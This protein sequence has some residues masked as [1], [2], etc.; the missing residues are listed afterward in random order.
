MGR[1]D[2]HRARALFR[3]SIFVRDDGDQTP[4][5]RQAHELAD[6]MLIA[7]VLGMDGNRRIAQHGFGAGGRHDNL[8]RAVFQRIGEVPIE[9]VNL[10]LLDLE[11]GDGG[12]ELRVPIDQTLVAIDQALLVEG[13]KDL[14]H[15]LGQA[16]I[17]GK[18]LAAPVAGDPKTTKLVL[19]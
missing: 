13:D 10:T 7:F 16:L 2:L 19:N 5:D 18:A 3:V 4:N 9:A 15:S 17:K 11:V 14:A 8:A 6:Q 12:L 1:R